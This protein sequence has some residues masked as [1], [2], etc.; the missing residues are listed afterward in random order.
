VIVTMLLVKKAKLF[1]CFFPLFAAS[2]LASL[3]KEKPT[4]RDKKV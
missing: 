4:I 1:M 3:Q 2:K